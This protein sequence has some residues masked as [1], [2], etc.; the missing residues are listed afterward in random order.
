MFFRGDIKMRYIVFFIV[1]VL[2]IGCNVLSV[3]KDRLP[4]PHQVEDGWLFQF[5]DPTAR[6]VQLAGTFNDW[7][8][9]TQR[10]RIDLKKNEK[11]IWTVVVPLE[12]GRHQYKFVINLGERWEFDP[13]N[14]SRD[15]YGGYENSL[16]IIP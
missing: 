3:V 2:F 1:S 5:D 13:S 7:E 6:E 8:Y 11:G 16:I 9:G 15:R 12:K 4:P 10:Q 14:P